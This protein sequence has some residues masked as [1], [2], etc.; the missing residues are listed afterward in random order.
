MVVKIQLSTGGSSTQQKF[1][2]YNQTKEIFI[3]ADVDENILMLMDDEMKKYFEV[4]I[5][6]TDFQFKHEVLNITW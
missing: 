4:E 6:P 5:S 3:E 2:M 1:L